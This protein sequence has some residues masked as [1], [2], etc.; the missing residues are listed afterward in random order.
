V[1]RLPRHRCS[2]ELREPA[3]L[4]IDRA[5][6]A[7]ATEV[8]D[9][10]HALPGAVRRHRHPRGDRMT[11]ATDNIARGEAG[12]GD[13]LI[14]HVPSLAT[15]G[16]CGAMPSGVVRRCS[17][18]AV[19]HAGAAWLRPA[20]RGLLQSPGS[21]RAGQSIRP[22][23]DGLRAGCYPSEP[24]APR[25]R[26]SAMTGTAQPD[27]RDASTDVVDDPDR[28]RSSRSTESEPKVS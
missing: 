20:I 23:A 6:A 3:W 4:G 25:D 26:G 18:A 24:I 14:L 22:V 2:R 5:W 8:I 9:V 19:T 12:G 1:R 13:A 21:D 11:R 16:F 27:R 10:R 28:R 17:A 15:P 7:V